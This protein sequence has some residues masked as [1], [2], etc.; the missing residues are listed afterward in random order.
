MTVSVII[1]GINGWEEY[2]RPLIAD[3]WTHEPDA[4]IIC[5][6]NASDTPYPTAPHIHRLDERVCYAG[7]INHG[8]GLAQGDWLLVLNND[9]RC[10][11]KFLHLVEAL[12][13]NTIYGMTLYSEPTFDWLSSWIFAM[14]R[15]IFEKVGL[16]D[17]RFEVCAYEDVDYCYRA[18]K[19]GIETKKMSL[20]FMH[21]DGKTRWGLPQYEETRQANI[22]R[23]QAKWGI[24][25]QTRV[26][27]E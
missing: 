5:I 26:Y 4:D 24:Q 9:V 2:T 12:D 8:I 13:K 25:L 27:H 20:P 10:N 11:D 17:I 15:S 21:L 19:G 23:F 18:K 7:A 14:H 16:F 6:D 3:I 1:V 22:K